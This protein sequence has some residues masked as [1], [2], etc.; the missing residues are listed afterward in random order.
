[1]NPVNWAA[2]AARSATERAVDWSVVAARASLL[3]ALAA[4]CLGLATLAFR[5]YARTM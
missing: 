4:V 3:A 5:S 1:L 2:V